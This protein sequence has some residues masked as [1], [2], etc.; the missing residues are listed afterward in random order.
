VFIEVHKRFDPIYNDARER[1]RAM[2]DFGYFT[3]YMS[4]PKYQLLT[5]KSWAGK[6][7]DISYYLNSHHIDFH[8]W[9]CQ[10]NAIPTRVYATAAKGVAKGKYWVWFVVIELIFLGSDN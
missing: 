7:S 6:S 3:A 2:G 1:I 4:Q 8:V 9:A 5:F 10:G